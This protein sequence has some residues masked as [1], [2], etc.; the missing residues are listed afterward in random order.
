MIYE[1]GSLTEYFSLQWRWLTGSKE[2]ERPYVI[3]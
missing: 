2:E 3:G 1:Q